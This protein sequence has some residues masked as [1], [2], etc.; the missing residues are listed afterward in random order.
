MKIHPHRQHLGIYHASCSSINRNTKEI[1][2]IEFLY[3][4]RSLF[5]GGWGGGGR[6]RDKEDKGRNR[7]SEPAFQRNRGRYAF[8][9]YWP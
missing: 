7:N 9:T 2:M 8:L 6:G 4:E 3:E 1:T 5:E